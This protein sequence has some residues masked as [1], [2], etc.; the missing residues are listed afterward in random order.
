MNTEKLTNSNFL[1][2]CAAHYKDIRFASTED[3]NAD[4]NRIKYIKKL[5]TRFIKNDNLKERI[6]LNHII[7]LKN[8]FG[9]LILNRIL[10]L[11]FKDQ[12]EYVKP[13]LILLDIFQEKIYSTDEEKIVD[14][15]LIKMNS[16][17]VE[18]LRQI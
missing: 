13:F 12:M 16:K 15:R 7:I 1:L 18:R 2:F 8:C 17:I 6:I 11:K 3:F 9:P 14:L 5:L 4:I 10:Y